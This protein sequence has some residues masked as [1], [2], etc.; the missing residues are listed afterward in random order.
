MASDENKRPAWKCNLQ[1]NTHVISNVIKNN[2]KNSEFS[3][4]ITVESVEWRI[5]LDIWEQSSIFEISNMSNSFGRLI[6]N[7]NIKVSWKRKSIIWS[8]AEWKSEPVIRYFR[9]YSEEDPILRK[10]S[11]DSS[12]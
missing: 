8:N 10:S 12:Y 1:F 7:Q 4:S 2:N 11:C 5:Q 6:E 3:I 9:S